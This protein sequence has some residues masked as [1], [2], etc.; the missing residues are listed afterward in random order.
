M[1]LVTVASFIAFAL[2][3]GFRAQEGS[4]LE[5]GLVFGGIDSVDSSRENCWEILIYSDFC[6]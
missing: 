3:L 6:L 5:V 2:E 4:F 1:P